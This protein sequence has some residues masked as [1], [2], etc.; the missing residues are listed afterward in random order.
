MTCPACGENQD[1][2]S[3][4]REWYGTKRRRRECLKCGERWSTVEVRYEIGDTAPVRLNNKRGNY[5]R[6]AKCDY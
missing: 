2:V 3:D 1:I 5:R 6:R 4:S